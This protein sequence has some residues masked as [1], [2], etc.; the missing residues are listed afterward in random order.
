M[1][2]NKPVLPV[3][4]QGREGG[5]RAFMV[6]YPSRSWLFLRLA[7]LLPCLLGLITCLKEVQ[8]TKRHPHRV[9]KQFKCVH[10]NHVATTKLRAG[11]LYRHRKMHEWSLRYGCFRSKSTTLYLLPIR[12]FPPFLMQSI[13]QNRWY[14]TRSPPRHTHAS[15]PPWTVQLSRY[16]WSLTVIREGSTRI[17]WHAKLFLMYSEPFLQCCKRWKRVLAARLLQS[18][19]WLS[20]W[21]LQ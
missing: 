10:Y 9:P 11:R 12:C 15:T 13:A 4:F 19:C 17:W 5:G 1:L 2:E 21:S 6:G 3:L 7:W 14:Y 8:R 20:L 16:C 18:A